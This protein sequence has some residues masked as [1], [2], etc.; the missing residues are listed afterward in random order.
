MP[1]SSSAA[2]SAS[3]SLAGV[4]PEE[5]RRVAAGVAEPGGLE[6][7]QQHVALGAVARAHLL[8]VRLVA[9]RRDRRALDELR[10]RD[11]DVRAGSA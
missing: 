10:R 7:R 6:R 4:E 2:A 8:D 1:R 9:P 11:A 5:E 3:A